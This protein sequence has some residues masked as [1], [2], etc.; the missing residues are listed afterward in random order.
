PQAALRAAVHLHGAA[1]D[2]LVAQG[3]GPI[4]LTA[5]DTI[6]AAQRLLNEAMR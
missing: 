5:T 1:A 4:G 2:A 3:C 6:A